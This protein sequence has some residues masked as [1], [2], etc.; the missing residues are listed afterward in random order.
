MTEDKTPGNDRFR[1]PTHEK[2]K[3]VWINNILQQL[4]L[5]TM[6]TLKDTADDENTTYKRIKTGLD[7]ELP[8]K[9]HK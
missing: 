8:Y 2:R 5:W 9:Y 3:V 6:V 7:E 4:S 1:F